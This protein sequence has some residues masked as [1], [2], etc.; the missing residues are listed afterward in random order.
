MVKNFM[1]VKSENGQKHLLTIGVLLKKCVK[2]YF[3]VQCYYYFSLYQ[4]DFNV[5]GSWKKRKEKTWT[6]GSSASRQTVLQLAVEKLNWLQK[7]LCV[8]NQNVH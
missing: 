8:A 1:N 7:K 6:G 3:I 4:K 5:Y 2:M